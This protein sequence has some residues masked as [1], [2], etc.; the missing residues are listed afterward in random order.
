MN[1]LKRIGQTLFDMGKQVCRLPLAIGGAFRRG[2]RQK[3]MDEAEAERLD[4]IR[5]PDKY[6]GRE[7]D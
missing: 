6:L 1:T 3:V 2:R 7:S 5:H 4:R